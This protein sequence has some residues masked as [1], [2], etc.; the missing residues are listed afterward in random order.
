MR[1]LFRPIHDEFDAFSDA[2]KTAPTLSSPSPQTPLAVRVHPSPPR[3]SRLS[4]T[5]TTPSSSS[6]TSLFAAEFAVLGELGRGDFGVV[7]LCRWQRDGLLYAVKRSLAPLRTSAERQRACREV[8]HFSLLLSPASPPSS[9]SPHP[10]VM[11]M[12]QAFWEERH[13]YIQ[14]E[15]LPQGTV[16]DALTSSDSAI[17]EERLWLW[18]AD[19]VEGLHFLHSHGVLHLDI[20]P[21]NLFVSNDGGIK[22]G[23]LGTSARLNAN[24]DDAKEGAT[25]A[26]GAVEEVEEGDAV[27]LAPELL[28]HSVGPV[29][30]AADVFSLGLTMF[31]LA[32]DVLLP[33]RG[34]AWND[35]RH[36]VVDWTGASY[37]E[38]PSES[39]ARLRSASPLLLDYA[40]SAMQEEKEHERQRQLP[41]VPL[42]STRSQQ[43]PRPPASTRGVNGAVMSPPSGSSPALRSLPATSPAH[44]PLSD[45]DS[46]GS[47]QPRTPLCRLHVRARSTPSPLHLP[48]GESRGGS[49]S[50]TLTPTALTRRRSSSSGVGQS[51]NLGAG[52]SRSLALQSLISSM[53]ARTP[54]QRPTLQKLRDHPLV[55]QARTRR[56]QQRQQQQSDERRG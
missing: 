4:T 12:Y 9:P 48:T 21:D 25:A 6:T 13:L 18:L 17:A 23:D 19:A 8:E 34:P 55:L 33:M 10:N 1:P 38:A 42:H 54:S 24:A 27:Y 51:A 2:A 40:H 50:P 31:E 5:S 16:R 53:L 56:E 3:P 22:V 52:A 7:F 47:P 32:A 36:A 45:E 28:D 39:P 41:R 26:S 46:L 11:T 15:Y 29:T 49:R 43:Q 44:S 30:A 37:H 35:L 14:S 20:K